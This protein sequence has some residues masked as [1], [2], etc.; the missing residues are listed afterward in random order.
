[1]IMMMFACS[2]C[3]DDARG[4]DNARG[5]DGRSDRWTDRQTPVGGDDSSLIA[6]WTSVIA[7][8]R[9][10]SVLKKSI[11]LTAADTDPSRTGR[12][13]VKISRN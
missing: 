5:R 12:L 10:D 7:F 6:S 11:A 8:T 1:M 9:S 3:D 2:L 4:R 13:K